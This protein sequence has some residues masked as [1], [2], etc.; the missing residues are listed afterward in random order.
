[1]FV[2]AI[3]SE[4]CESKGEQ[5]WEGGGEILDISYILWFKALVGA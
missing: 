5:G 3:E 1:M 2:F 4:R